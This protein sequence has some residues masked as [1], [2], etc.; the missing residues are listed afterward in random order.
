MIHFPPPTYYPLREIS[1]HGHQELERQYTS[2]GLGF[3]YALLVAIE[4][5]ASYLRFCVH[6][7]FRPVFDGDNPPRLMAP[8]RQPA[9]GELKQ[10]KARL[11]YLAWQRTEVAFEA[12]PKLRVANPKRRRDRSSARRKS[13]AEGRGA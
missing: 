7:R 13:K 5:Q 1:S 3:H 8:T 11:S 10:V 9:A 12:F 6:H 4:Q 2:A